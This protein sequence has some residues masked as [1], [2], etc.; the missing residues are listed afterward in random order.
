MRDSETSKGLADDMHRGVRLGIQVWLYRAEKIV[1][2]EQSNVRISKN[3]YLI[4][5]YLL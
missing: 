3:Y 5:K 4:R 2:E 1:M